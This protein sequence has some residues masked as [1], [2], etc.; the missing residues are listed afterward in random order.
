MRLEGEFTYEVDGEKVKSVDEFY[1]LTNNKNYN[2]V[3]DGL[4]IITT[5]K[6][7]PF[8]LDEVVFHSFSPKTS[9]KQNEKLD[10][11]RDTILQNKSLQL[12]LNDFLNITGADSEEELKDILNKL[13]NNKSIAK[14]ELEKATYELNF[15]K[16]Y[17][18]KLPVSGVISHT[19]GSV[20][21]KIQDSTLDVYNAITGHSTRHKANPSTFYDLCAGICENKNLI[22]SSKESEGIQ[23]KDFPEGFGWYNMKRGKVIDYSKSGAK[24]TENKVDYSEIDWDFIE[25]LAKRMS[26]N[27]D[28]YIVN[29]WKAPTDLDKLKQALLRHVLEVLKGNYADGEDELGHLEAIALNAQFLNY[30]IKNIK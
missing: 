22:K 12:D 16:A 24:E 13:E 2:L 21:E 25:Q 8:F 19:G 20:F 18:F 4:N 9:K 1:K 14:K 5:S 7:E 27:K 15:D 26:K 17:D 29:N 28:K 6:S 11:I 3:I 30:Q 10:L 23:S